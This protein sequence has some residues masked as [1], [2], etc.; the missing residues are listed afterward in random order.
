MPVTV[1]DIIFNGLLQ[2]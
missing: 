1:K 2:Q